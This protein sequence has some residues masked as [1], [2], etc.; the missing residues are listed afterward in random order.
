MS[1]KGDSGLVG[2]VEA[3]VRAASESSSDL[4]EFADAVDDDD[5]LG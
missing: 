2:G 5:T 3:L 1:G 4:D